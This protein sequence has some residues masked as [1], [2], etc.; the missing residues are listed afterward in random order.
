MFT[1]LVFQNAFQL[2]A[3]C[4]ISDETTLPCFTA[5]FLCI[6][7]ANRNYQTLCYSLKPSCGNC[8]LTT[9]QQGS[10]MTSASIQGFAGGSM[11]RASLQCLCC[12]S[13]L[14]HASVPLC[15]G[16]METHTAQHTKEISSQIVLWLR[17]YNNTHTTHWLLSMHIVCTGSFSSPRPPAEGNREF[18]INSL[19]HL[20]GNYSSN[21]VGVGKTQAITDQHLISRK[22]MLIN[23]QRYH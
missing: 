13:A 19:N 17:P 4:G 3:H 20:K 6:N 11:C 8:R 14:P 9:L 22:H 2:S 10:E 5:F 1:E 16:R 12:G 7:A 23:L 15:G 21:Q 18:L